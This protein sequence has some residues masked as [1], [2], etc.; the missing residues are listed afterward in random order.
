MAIDPGIAGQAVGLF[1]VTNL[2]DLLVLALFFAQG[3]GRRH[4]TR[5]IA[6]GQYLGFTAILAVA[7]AAALGATLLPERAVP[8]LGLLPLALG[9]R[10]AIRAWRSR[11]ED[12]EE[13][14]S[15]GGPGILEVATVT[16]ANGGDNLGVYVPVLAVAGPTGASV[17]VVV[18][19][20]LVAVWVAAGRFLATR[21]LIAKALSRWGHVLLPIVL[22]G[23]GLL[24]LIEGGVL[25]R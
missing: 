19:L 18:F 6:I 5:S 17:Y 1:A 11:G 3:A 20:V 24:I 10:A 25:R 15:D 13:G 9:V 14:R 22:I 2:D 16:F 4:A 23:I 8:Y 12:D 7:V 21:P